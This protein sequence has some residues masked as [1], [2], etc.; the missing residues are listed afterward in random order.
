MNTFVQRLV[1]TNGKRQVGMAYES[2]LTNVVLSLAT[3]LSMYFTVR[4][5]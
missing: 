1:L 3:L 4:S 2:S 5:K